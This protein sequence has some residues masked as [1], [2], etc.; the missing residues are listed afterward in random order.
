[1]KTRQG[2][3]K[4]VLVMT[5]LIVFSLTAPVMAA[6]N[7]E[8]M[9]LQ[10][11]LDTAVKNNPA[12]A[13]S[14]QR[15]EEKIGQIPV[16]SAWANPKFG[17]MK[18]DI[19]NGLFA[20]GTG[21]MTQYT[22]KQDIMNPA[23][24][25][26]MGKMASSDAQMAEANYHDK[27]LDAYTTAKVD[28][29]DLMYASKALEIGKENQQLMGQ[30]VQIAQV[31]YSTGMVSLQD[32]LRAQTEFSTMTT[33][34]LNMASMEA[35]AKAKLNT[36]MGRPANSV[37]NV[38]EE[39]SAPPPNFDLASLTKMTEGKPAI[40]SMQ[41]Q[42]EMAQNGVELA[43]NQQLPDYEVSLAYEDYQQQPHTWQVEV[44]AMLPI[45]QDKNKGQI[46]SANASLAAAQASL[47]NMQNMTGLD[48]QMALTEAQTAWRKID[49]YQT[50]IIPQAEQTY[51]AG[52]VSYT[53]GKVD[54]MSVLDSLNVLRNVKLGYYQAHIDYEKAV[55]NLEKA[56]GK[57]M[58]IS[59]TQP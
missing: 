15:W 7:Q 49:L 24:L 58:F 35:V 8:S 46:K 38:K 59:G 51:Q 16:A 54:F 5:A 22:L 39:F 55:A 13:E 10:Q 19:E 41:R 48:I 11:I 32:V 1:M 12:V 53:N 17:I 28:Y 34:L 52:V 26:S 2:F 37:L 47:T 3:K 36:A 31:N 33:D 40:V 45:W 42:V 9:T 27:W 20:P 30:L 29:Y 23:K 25:K 6:E 50:T 44:M 57:P 56:V 21:M 18:D 14:E 43:N 4:Q